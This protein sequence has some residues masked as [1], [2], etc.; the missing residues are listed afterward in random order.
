MKKKRLLKTIILFVLLSVLTTSM[1]FAQ[2]YEI[3]VKINNLQPNDT[4][5]LG[6]YF[7][8]KMY[9]DDTTVL[10]AKG[11]GVFRGSEPMK[12]GMYL[13][14]LPTKNY[15]DILI[16]EDQKF[17]IENDTTDFNKNIKIEGSEENKL[18]YNFKTFM[19]KRY[20]E[21]NELQAEKRQAQASSDRKKME[22]IDKQINKL[23]AERNEKLNQLIDEHP[24]TFIAKF[25]K[26]TKEVE[27][28][29]DI[30][31]KKRYYYYKEH[32]FDNFDISD[33][34]LL[35]TPIYQN[36][37]DKY[38]EILPPVV[39]SI[40]P[41]VD[42]LIKRSQGDEELFRFM[43]AH[44]YNTYNAHKLIIM[45]E[46]FVHIAKNY[47]LTGAASWYDEESRKK[48]ADRVRKTEPNLIGKTA[49]PLR[50]QR[51]P[52][53]STRIKELK[54]QIV[55]L[56]KT[57]NEI[58]NNDAL[59]KQEKVNKSVEL[60]NSYYE[61]IGTYKSLYDLDAQFTLI[62]FWEP[63]CS[64]CR[65]ETPVLYDDI[66][67]Q[68]NDKGLEVYAVFL[69]AFV[70]DWSD[71]MKEI[72]HWYSF[73]QKH[74]IYDWNNVWDPYH[75]TKFRDLY[76]INSSP[77]SYLLDEKRTIIFK[78]VNAEQIK[79]IIIELFISDIMDSTDNEN[80][81]VTKLIEFAT[82]YTKNDIYEQIKKSVERLS[83]TNNNKEKIKKHIDKQLKKLE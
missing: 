73:I 24:N 53:D 56:K 45:E 28:P 14:F 21:V 2:G 33:P 36:K 43:L 10:N 60:F 29:D 66:Y 23:V 47:Y 31:P 44:L 80:E 68:F 3:K 63:K 6:H 81:Q 26:A 35:R 32:Y 4:V 16:N 38:L 25:L 5:V 82:G 70:E 34:R 41:K 57:G 61:P 76:N 48:L 46:V 15:F 65:K 77:V 54:E 11:E 64:H 58:W 79:E 75:Q 7:A 19:D 71:F 78:R 22:K 8:N 51:I 74:E 55:D 18:F 20:K 1:S 72:D 30:A 83:L 62:W 67:K 52:Q 13:I 59:K 42:M 50:M 17:Y 40:I 27:V 37:I 9:P 39:D 49:P 12:G 69:Q